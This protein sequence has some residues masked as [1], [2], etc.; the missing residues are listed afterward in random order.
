M[1]AIA[2]I[3]I[4]ES[5]VPLLK[6][7]YV[8]I[9]FGALTWF[10]GVSAIKSFTARKVLDDEPLLVIKDGK[11]HEQ[12][13]KHARLTKDSLLPLLRQ[14]DIFY[15]GEVEFAFFETD[16]SL[17]PYKKPNQKSDQATVRGV[18]QTFI[19]DGKILEDSLQATGK[20]KDWVAHILKTRQ[21]N[22]RDVFVAQLDERGELYVDMRNDKH[23]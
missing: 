1:G 15:L 21:I 11:I 18:P 10:L 12:G 17:S 3:M 9:L 23:F 16:G 14:K 7:G 6:G 22:L 8:V 19:M 13:M 2:S 4:L 20:N 5:R